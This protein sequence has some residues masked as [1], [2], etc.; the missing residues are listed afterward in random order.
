MRI[1]IVLDCIDPDTLVPFWQEALGYRL[2]DSLDGY[3]ILVPRE[4]EP[5]GPVL[6][7]QPV[8]EPKRG[9]NRMH[10]DVHPGD[11]AAH[12]SQ[13][14]SL[15]ATRLGAPIASFGVTWQTLTDPEGHE[16]C[17]VSHGR[18]DLDDPDEV[19]Q[20]VR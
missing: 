16:F 14:E 13:L 9:K 6:I 1:S 7:L 5:P 11:A 17:V 3:R 15:G 4:G 10:I 8:P 19:D 2:A 12:I 20:E 18:L